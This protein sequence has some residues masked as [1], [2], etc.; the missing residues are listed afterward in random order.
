MEITGNSFSLRGL[1]G[2]VKVV[3]DSA[4]DPEGEPLSYSEEAE[5][6]VIVESKGFRVNK[7][8][9]LG[10][11]SV[12]AFLGEL[13]SLADKGEGRASLK[14]P[15]GELSL[16]FVY[17]KGVARVECAMNDLRDGN[18]NFVSVKYLIEPDYFTALVRELAKRQRPAAD[19][20]PG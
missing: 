19:R 6:D 2:L 12:S 20:N 17:E 7:V 4:F 8:M 9:L 3:S 11:P 13:R 1:S 14:A 15:S 18:E 5:C 10:M 16:S